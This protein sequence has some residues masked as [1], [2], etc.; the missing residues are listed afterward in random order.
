M[1]WSGDI[2]AVMMA[3]NEK[4]SAVSQRLSALPRPITSC[5]VRYMNS[6]E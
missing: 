3:A 6:A 1:K 4:S 5:S 2:E